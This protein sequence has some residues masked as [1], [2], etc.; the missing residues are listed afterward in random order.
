MEVS[1]IFSKIISHMGYGLIVHDQISQVFGFLNLYGYQYEHNQHYFEENQ[2]YKKIQNYFIKHFHRLPPQESIPKQAII[3]ENWYKYTS[4]DVDINTKR[5]TI[6]DLMKKWIVWEK[7]AIEVF[8]TGYK[9]LREKEEFAAAKLIENCLLETTEEL[10]DA[11]RE[12]INLETIN[13]D[14]SV[15]VPAQ[16]ELY[17]NE[18]DNL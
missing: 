15:I 7:E 1:E 3:P 10:A 12:F 2:N 11:E 9:E 18:D 6:Q 4:F 8:K 5:N 14:M 17:K 13:Y 16:K